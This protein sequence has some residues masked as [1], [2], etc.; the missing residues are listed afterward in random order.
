MNIYERQELR[1][2]KRQRQV[3]KQKVTL[4]VISVMIVIIGSIVFGS[5]FTSAKENTQQQV[6]YKYYKSIEIEAG[7]S[8]WSIA[9]VYTPD[10]KD[11]NVYVDE[12]ME[13]NNLSSEQ[14]HAGQHLLVPYYDTE[15][16]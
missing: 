14:I 8:L 5:L 13:L 4:L 6:Q 15:Y 10:N 16:R 2:R 11:V 3:A 12:L 9:Q 7:E 1:R